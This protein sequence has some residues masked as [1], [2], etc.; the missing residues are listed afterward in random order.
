MTKRGKKRQKTTPVDSEDVAVSVDLEEGWI[1]K[2][3]ELTQDELAKVLADIANHGKIKTAAIKKARTS[4]PS[5]CGVEWTDFAQ[6]FGL[7]E[8]VADHEFEPVVTPVYSL[9]PSVHEIM[10]EAAWR[11]QDVYQERRQQ[12]RE[13]ARV[14]IMDPVRQRLA[15]LFITLYDLSVCHAQYLVR[16]IGLFQ[17][18]VIDRPEQAMLETEYA[19]GGGVEHE[20]RTS[21]HLDL[22]IS[23]NTV[24]RRSS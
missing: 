19:T 22:L 2:F 12:T 11:T 15:K 14:R 10:F 5:F 6:E 21:A 3:L 7:A 4:L 17:G 24:L 9:P 1:N 20:V 23:L 8:K 13:A 16:I 18:R